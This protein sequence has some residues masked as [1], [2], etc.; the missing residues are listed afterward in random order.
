MSD[1]DYKVHKAWIN[2]I[3]FEILILEIPRKELED[4]LAYLAR[5]KGN[6][7]KNYY[8]DFVIA[9]CV[10]NINQLIFNIRSKAVEDADLVLIREKIMSI[11]VG[12]NPLLDSSNLVVNRNSVIKL[13]KSDDLRE[14]ERLLTDNK[15]WNVPYLE[16][17]DPKHPGTLSGNDEES[18]KKKI[19]IREIK[20]IHDIY[21]SVTKK[22][23]NRIRQY[24]EIKEFDAAD[25]GSL[26]SKKFFHDKSSFQTYIVTT[27]V[28]DS[29]GFFTKLDSMGVPSRVAPPILME[30]VYNLCQEANVFLTFENA[31]EFFDF[32]LDSEDREDYD[33]DYNKKR[34]SKGD[35]TNK[36]S[37]HAKNVNKKKKKKASFKD[38][39]KADLLKLEDSM[40]VFVIGQ[41]KAVSTITEA[42]K[43]ASVGLK[44]P[45]KPI[46]S[47]LFAGKTGIGKCV[48]KGSLVFSSEG[49]KPIESFCKGNKID[50][51]EVDV[52]GIDGVNKTSHIYKE[53]IKNGR[54]ITTNNG[55]NLGGSMIHPIVTINNNGK[56]EFKKFHELTTNDYVAI[57]YNQNYFSKYNTDLEFSFT[58]KTHDGHSKIYKTPIVM[59]EDLA[60]YIGLL[61]GDGCLSIDGRIIF[62]NKDKQ[63]VNSFYNLS[64]KLFGIVPK[65]TTNKHDYYYSSVYIYKFLKYACGVS[66]SLSINK[67]FPF[68]ILK[69]NKECIASFIRGLMDT[70][71]Y[72]EKTGVIGIT[73]ATKTLINQLQ[74]V[75]LN[76]GIV[77]SIRHRLIKYKD[78]FNDAWELSIRSKFLKIFVKEIGFSLGAKKDIFNLVCNKKYNPN[79]DIIPNIHEALH[80][81]V[82]KYKLN[83]KFHRYYRGYYKGYRKPSRKKLNEILNCLKS[84]AGDDIIKNETFKHLKTVANTDIFWSK[85]SSIEEVKDMD[86]YD[87]TVPVTH[88]FISNGFISHNTLT[89]KVLANE[90]IKDKNNLVT[91]DCSEY[92]A[93][94]EYAKLIGAPS[95]YVGHEQ[96]GILTNAVMESPF[97]VVVFDEIEK[98]SHKVHELMLQILEEGR[99]T[100][101]KG[102]KV[103][104]KDTIIIMTSNIGVGEVEAIRKTI[105]F[106]DVAKVTE[107][108]KNKAIGA[109]IKSKFKPEFLNRID[110]VVHFSGLNKEDY[111][112]IIDIEL[113]KLNQNL[114]D[115]NTEYKTLNLEFNKLVKNFIYKNGINEDFGARPLKRCIENKISTPLANVLLSR[116]TSER[117]TVKVSTKK[118]KAVFK[119]EEVKEESQTEELVSFSKGVS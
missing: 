94:H 33:I 21:Y 110:S 6:I 54:R 56:F 30:E 108:K 117:A 8:E 3:D 52:C 78:G 61:T 19:D 113:Y 23:W 10:A 98:A 17:K 65:S 97:S 7:T 90:L 72:F 50:K 99:L 80:S 32:D 100:D 62:S 69:S 93:D 102:N 31:K 35:A 41:D 86:L 105:G 5:D 24:I 92:S 51:L 116:E 76:F 14:D 48:E 67:E 40:K 107:E 112:R 60:Y 55:F 44:D 87:F 114:K 18:D 104:F 11:V 9:T 91:I 58:K 96:G 68:S 66:M 16:E 57:Q 49:I 71:G 27:C 63:L 79:K 119:I 59:S 74:T 15:N 12:V 85:I 88:T 25:I 2:D 45:A 109:A 82:K 36:M 89:S 46:G 34:P 39:K 64:E 47:F 111:M 81:L 118:G 4:K 77:S 115:N 38:L 73:L 101:G 106:G 26:L 1:S 70:D 42:V 103:S 95:G 20:D 22:W 43:R 13:K 53:G 37:S 83:R 75:L 28:V 84:F 29:K